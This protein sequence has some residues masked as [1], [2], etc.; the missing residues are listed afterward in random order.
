MCCLQPQ[1]FGIRDVLPGASA[2]RRLTTRGKVTA[3]RYHTMWRGA[4]YLDQRGRDAVSRTIEMNAHALARNRERHRHWFT[5][6]PT[7]AVA[8]RIEIV[9]LDNRFG[10]RLN[11]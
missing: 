8:R 11:W 10:G 1:L 7:D 2:T 3:A 6:D 4:E 5:P 9:D